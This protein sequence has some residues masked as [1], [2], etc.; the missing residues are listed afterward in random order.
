MADPLS[1]IDRIHEDVA[2]QLIGAGLSPADAGINAAF[3]ASRYEA[4]ANRFGGALG[5]AWDLYQAEGISIKGGAESSAPADKTAA[6]LQSVG[7]DLARGRITMAPGR[8]VIDLLADADASTFL[9]ECSHLWLDELIRDAQHPAAPADLRQDL[10]TILDWLEVRSPADITVDHHEKWARDFERFAMEGQ[11]PNDRLRGV[12]QKFRTWLTGIYRS[13]EVLDA[14][15]SDPVRAVMAR[16]VDTDRQ[17]AIGAEAH[18]SPRREDES[19][20]V[21]QGTS[22]TIPLSRVVPDNYGYWIFPD[23]QIVPCAVAAHAESACAQLGLDP[24]AELGD[25]N[26]PNGDNNFNIRM[27]AIDQSP[28]LETSPRDSSPQ[29][30][31]PRETKTMA[32]TS[33]LH[34]R[35]STLHER[36]KDLSTPSYSAAE[37]Y[38]DF[39]RLVADHGIDA[40]NAAIDSHPDIGVGIAFVS[41]EEII[42][43]NHRFKVEEGQNPALDDAVVA[44]AR[45]VAVAKPRDNE[46]EGEILDREYAK[47]I[48]ELSNDL[49]PAHAVDKR[50]VTQPR[51]PWQAGFPPVLAQAEYVGLKGHP[52][53]RAAKAGDDLAAGRVAADLIDA[54]PEQIAAIKEIVGDR[55]VIVVPVTAIEKS[56]RNKLPTAYAGELAERLGGTLDENIVQAAE[57]H[58]GGA[59]AYHRMAFPAPFSGPVEAGADYIIVDDTVAMGGTL[60][61]LKGHIETHGGHVILATT[62]ATRSATRSLH[63]DLS[64]HMKGRLIAKYGKAVDEFCQQEFGYGIDSLTEGEAGHLR[65][66]PSLDAVR[67]R[68]V[69]ARN[70]AL[71]PGAGEISRGPAGGGKRSGYESLIPRDELVLTGDETGTLEVRHA[72]RVLGTVTRRAEGYL[73]EGPAA[74]VLLPPMSSLDEALDLL[75]LPAEADQM[76]FNEIGIGEGNAPLEGGRGGTSPSLGSEERRAVFAIHVDATEAMLADLEAH[77]ERFSPDINEAVRQARWE[78]DFRDGPVILFEKM[79]GTIL[80]AVREDYLRNKPALWIAA[81]AEVEKGMGFDYQYDALHDSRGGWVQNGELWAAGYKEHPFQTS[82]TA[83]E[84]GP[85]TVRYVDRDGTE[86]DVGTFANSDQA[87]AFIARRMT[88]IFGPDPLMT[89][90]VRSTPERENEAGMGPGRDE[91]LPGDDRHPGEG[92]GPS[93]A[94]SLGAQAPDSSNSRPAQAGAFPSRFEA[95]SFV[96][97]GHTFRAAHELAGWAGGWDWQ[98]VS[99]LS[100]EAA[101]VLGFEKEDLDR[102]ARCVLDGEAKTTV[103]DIGIARVTVAGG[104]DGARDS[105]EIVRSTG[106]EG[107]DRIASGAA[108]LVGTNLF[109]MD[110]ADPEDLDRAAAKIEQGLNE[111]S[112][113][114][115]EQVRQI[116]IE[117][118]APD[119]PEFHPIGEEWLPLHA[120]GLTP[121]D[122]WK[123]KL[124]G[125]QG[126][127]NTIPGEHTPRADEI[128]ASVASGGLPEAEAPLGRFV[129]EALSDKVAIGHFEDALPEDPAVFLVVKTGRTGIAPRLQ[130]YGVTTADL[131]G[132]RAN[133]DAVAAVCNTGTNDPWPGLHRIG[134]VSWENWKDKRNNVAMVATFQGVAALDKSQRNPERRLVPGL[135]LGQEN[136]AA[137]ARLGVPQSVSSVRFDPQWSADMR[138]RQE[139]RVAGMDRPTLRAAL[140]ATLS[141]AARAG[142]SS[143]KRADL[144]HGEKLIKLAIAARTSGKPP[145]EAFAEMRADYEAATSAD[146]IGIKSLM[147]LAG[148][149]KP[150]A[151]AVAKDPVV[152]ATL[153]DQQRDQVTSTI[154]TAAVGAKGVMRDDRGAGMGD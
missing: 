104:G 59:G 76:G 40:V 47:R 88:D 147:R 63:I 4:R 82:Y 132:V 137:L 3:V 26:D 127:D 16:M 53:Y 146:G 138:R 49:A 101:R 145:L 96:K 105:I 45:R 128:A 5:D 74:S 134:A 89:E 15:I 118:G 12:F 57:V 48:V 37:E 22:P 69:E 27:T 140:V 119:E 83:G 139:A 1:P 113:V 13:V 99:D 25:E 62:L 71:Q 148:D 121:D 84:G 14:P 42:V 32:D 10:Q 64:D 152:W 81:Q 11:A 94:P 114:W 120:A 126:R 70:E 19:S 51:T 125:E 60:A 93:P 85:V 122:A 92:L 149:A 124:Y 39:Q 123:A 17:N 144:G 30:Q 109:N 33:V 6:V 98:N 133:P 110:S 67:D 141:E 108:D 20:L 79:E 150:F 136:M 7:S 36:Y 54:A 66:A 97:F 29:I 151:E 9:H 38:I 52:D 55:R 91:S 107:I 31:T 44:A 2:A 95:D 28:A 75:T 80:P 129:Y 116:G 102:V 24:D 131:G 73:P 86:S 90:V 35:L 130:A 23:G 153:S 143:M 46:S 115:L 142:T 58:H 78:I 41:L 72:G 135:A 106:D 68:L 65:A 154:R 21:P 117:H 111:A 43:A 112:Q 87:A 77:P 50:N 34:D 56:G 18:Q 8:T 61:S 103:F 100:N